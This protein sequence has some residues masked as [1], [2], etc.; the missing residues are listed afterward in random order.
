MR[1]LQK[2]KN[3]NCWKKKHK[4]RNFLKKLDEGGE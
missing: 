1:A 3:H 4:K 2:E